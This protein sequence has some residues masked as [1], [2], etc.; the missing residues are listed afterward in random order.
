MHVVLMHV[1]RE[2]S[3]RITV[4]SLTFVQYHTPS[5]LC[6]GRVT[7]NVF[8]VRNPLKVFIRIEITDNRTL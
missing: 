7:G 5:G 4:T 3:R 8:F 2:S 1:T 6:V